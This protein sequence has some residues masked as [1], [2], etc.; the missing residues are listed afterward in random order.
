VRGAH[1]RHYGPVEHETKKSKWELLK[2]SA[3]LAAYLK[4]YWLLAVALL[5]LNVTMVGVGLIHPLLHGLFVQKAIVEQSYRWLAT[6]VAITIAAHLVS[7][8]IGFAS[9]Y[10]SHWV[11]QR[12]I[13]TLRNQL[14]GHLQTLSLRFFEGR[15]TGDIMA[16][17]TSDSEWV[18]QLIVHG[19]ARFLTAVLTLLWIAV[20]LFVTH[21]RLAALAIIP[22]PL[23]TAQVVFFGP[24]FHKIFMRV[25]EMFAQLNTFLQERISGVRIV[26][27][28][29]AE[30]L[31]AQRFREIT[32]KCYDAFMKA[33]VNFSLFEPLMGLL[34]AA[35]TVL[36]MYYGGRAAIRG[37]LQIWQIVAF[38]GYTG[39]FYAPISELGR[40]FGHSLPRSLAGADRIFEFLDERDQLPVAPEPIV[41]KRLEGRIEFQ[42]V[43]FKY[44]DHSVLK[45][46]NL[47]AEAGETVALVGPSGVGKTTIADL[48]S[49][50]YDPQEGRV[51]IDGVDAR[52]YDPIALRRQIGVVL[53]E[54]FLF[55]TTVR[56][57]IAYGMPG[58][59]DEQVRHAAR[60]AGA[61]EFIE[62]L[63]KGY[64]SLVGERG[65][66]LSV[67]EKQRISIARAL[68]KNPAILVLDEATSAVD[69]PT[70]RVIQQALE[71]AARGRTT[72]LI[73]H[74][75]STTT[76]ADRIIVLNEGVVAEDGSHA[77]LI[78]RDGMFA[79]LWEMQ[80]HL[81][82]PWPPNPEDRP[83]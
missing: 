70:E 32:R 53:Q 22:I 15:P 11:G 43:S 47:T 50:F 25:R 73:A 3:R 37:E 60:E 8:G 12:I 49:R 82:E 26:K 63:E 75:L 66:K 59:T 61:A 5:V 30:Q 21:A 19:V 74:R 27:S 38:L 23:V 80:A 24:R 46:L 14:Y 16:R 36:V 44:D 81:P 58:A 39:R 64:D 7:A 48:V 42:N 45:N 20:F 4:P 41:P 83:A 29:T 33:V 9:S 28:F 18:E 77:E 55:N 65:V 78:Q 51:L 71:R 31:E 67:G 10:G 62:K 79:K 68:L 34:S 40:L 57:N 72:I 52:D 56:E 76:M 54:P 2:S 69:T 13:L 17:V 35:G 6:L 1:G